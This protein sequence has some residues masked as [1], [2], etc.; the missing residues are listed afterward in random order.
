M[1]LARVEKDHR[2]DPTTVVI[3]ELGLCGNTVRADLAAVNGM[4]HGYEIKSDR[5]SLR[6]LE[7]QVEVYGRVFDRA[8]LVVGGRHIDRA[9]TMV[10]A[11]WGVLGILGCAV[12]PRLKIVRR[13]RAN[14]DVD[15]RVGPLGL[16]ESRSFMEGGTILRHKILKEVGMMSLVPAWTLGVCLVAV[17][18][19]KNLSPRADRFFRLSHK[20]ELLGEMLRRRTEISVSSEGP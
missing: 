3:S 18:L 6:R 15:P 20:H 19:M 10:P 1:L 9:T 13:G 14:P 11:W 16:R 8:T 17:D 4:I 12:A 2:H 7:T 5:D